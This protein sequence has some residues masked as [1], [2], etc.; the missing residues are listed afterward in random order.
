M[1]KITQLNY[2]QVID[3]TDFSHSHGA[4]EVHDPRQE[5]QIWTVIYPLLMHPTCHDRA[6]RTAGEIFFTRLVVIS[7]KALIACP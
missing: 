5:K 1:S 6:H 2:I 4:N 3:V 7:L